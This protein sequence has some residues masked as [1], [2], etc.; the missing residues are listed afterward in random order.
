MKE[1]FKYKKQLVAYRNNISKHIAKQTHIRTDSA[2][3]NLGEKRY[4]RTTLKEAGKAKQPYLV[5]SEMTK[6]GK[7]NSQ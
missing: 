7:N 2:I 1:P 5:F 3:K 6:P 4:A